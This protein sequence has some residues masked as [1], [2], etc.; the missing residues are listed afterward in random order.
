MVVFFGVN[1]AFVICGMFGFK[2]TSVNTELL[3]WSIM[4]S[5]NPV[6]LMYQGLDLGK[7]V[8]TGFLKTG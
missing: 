2:Q 6:G 4:I 3:A 1:A 5:E 7:G 8:I